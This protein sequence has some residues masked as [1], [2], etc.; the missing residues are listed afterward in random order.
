MV[1]AVV[2]QDDVSRLAKAHL[3]AK[4]AFNRLYCRFWQA[5]VHPCSDEMGWKLLETFRSAAEEYRVKLGREERGIQQAAWEVFR[6]ELT[7]EADYQFEDAVGFVKWYRALA[8]RIGA[9][10]GHLYEFHGDSFGDLID[11]YPLT[12]RELVE[13][14]LASHPKSARPRR[15]GYL[16][17]REVAEVVREKA[18]LA[19]YKVICQ[20]ENYIVR[21]LE[22]ACRRAY[23]HRILTGRDVRVTWTEDEQRA[24][25]FA[26]HYED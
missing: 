16:D 2:T 6:L 18:G 19:W 1:D 7:G 24:V 22:A 3:L 26:N 21:A 10:I 9:A 12:G 5:E 15:E 13:R 20:G 14:A 17:E 11:A 4:S 23:L 8:N 25:D